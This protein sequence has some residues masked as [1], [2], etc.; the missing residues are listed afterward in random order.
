MSQRKLIVIPVGGLSNRLRVI[1]SAYTLSRRYDIKLIVLWNMNIYLGCKYK[2]LFSN[3]AE[4]KICNVYDNHIT[5]RLLRGLLK[6]ENHNRNLKVIDERNFEDMCKQAGF[7]DTIIN[8][9]SS[10]NVLIETCKQFADTDYSFIDWNQKLVRRK[11]E[12]LDGRKP[13]IAIHI[14]R[15]D[16]QIA[17]ESSTDDKFCRIIESKLKEKKKI[18]LATDDVEL[19]HILINRY[20][21]EHIFCN[22]DDNRSRKSTSGMQNAVIDILCLA[23]SELI[24]E[25]Y[26]SSFGEM[27]SILGNTP[28]EE[29]I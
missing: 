29:V 13:Y 17:I 2:K 26:G 12:I 27:A 22:T 6:L 15:T 11:D 3:K 28:L 23:E 24:Y 21:N 5:H 7:Q 10:G 9:I 4:F 19:E 18:Y 8:A 1:A 14:R 25:S 20:G 16:H